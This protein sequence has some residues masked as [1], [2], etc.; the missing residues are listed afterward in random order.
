VPFSRFAGAIAQA[1]YA[2]G[3]L[4]ESFGAGAVVNELSFAAAFDQASF[5]ER[6]SSGGTQSAS[7][8]PVGRSPSN[9]DHG[10]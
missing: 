4:G 10:A 2:F 7:L 9:M 6:F 3:I 1:A 5:R 8:C